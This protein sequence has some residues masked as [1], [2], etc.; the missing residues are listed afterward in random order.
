MRDGWGWAGTVGEFL[1][2]PVQRW[3]DSLVDHHVAL[4]GLNASGSQIRAWD[5]EHAAMTSALRECVQASTGAADWSVVFE[6]ELPMEGGRR[7]DV[8]VLAGSTVVVLEFKDTGV[9]LP[10]YVDQVAAYSSDLSEF[11]AATHGRRVVP[12]V[13]LTGT[14]AVARTDD[15][16]I[17][18]GPSGLGHYLFDAYESG[19]IELATWLDAPYT[20]LPTLVAA[21]RRIF[22]HEPLPHVRRA[23]AVGIPETVS[24]LTGLVEQAE[25]EGRRMLALVTG[26]PGS[27]K[28][29]VGLRL[30]YERTG[31]TATA[32]FLSG[33][34][35]LVAVLQDALKSRVFVRDLHKFITSYGQT[36]KVPE[37]HVLVFD[38][39]QRAWDREYMHHKRGVPKSEP[40]LLTAIGE[41]L[42]GWAALVGL[43]GDG[44]EIHSGE[45]AGLGQWREALLPPSASERWQVHC[46]PRLVDDFSDLD[47]TTHDQLDLT[48]SLR[49]KRAEHLHDWVA[50]VLNGSPALANPLAQRIQAQ[51]YPMYLTRDLDAAKGY[52]RAMLGEAPEWRTGLLASSHA[53]LLPKYG[54]DNGFMATSRMNIAKW[55]NAPT[56]DPKSSNALTQPVTEFGCQ[57][58][59][60]DLPILCWGEDYR[61]QGDQWHKTPIRRKYRQDDPEELLRNAYRVLLTRGRE[62]LVI[63]LP[64]DPRLDLT[65]MVLL[66]AGLRVLPD[67]LEATQLATG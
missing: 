53:K 6:Y 66:A 60:L 4:L 65:E 2:T 49:T 48:I 13:V 54:I 40:E 41:R 26:V 3:R 20:P 17:T 62:G 24:L 64:D 21:A 36:T 33:N 14:D 12:L 8:V 37:Q 63:Y 29:L 50:R 25:D 58:L 57:G 47:V 31:T 30:V 28:T 1:S 18:T 46:A 7:P 51:A 38:E 23:L 56:D 67:Q 55:F 39:A 52:V 15:E 61:W 27:G 5:A 35:P 11:H 22:D 10:A 32:T 42:P 9:P 44:Q 43:V 19:D 45:E 16:V 59:E 34:G